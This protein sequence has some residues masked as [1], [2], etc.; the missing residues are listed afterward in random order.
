MCAIS[1]NERVLRFIFTGK[2]TKVASELLLRCMS[3]YKEQVMQ[4][5]AKN[6]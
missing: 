2:V 1:M 6:E 5:I 3:E 4:M